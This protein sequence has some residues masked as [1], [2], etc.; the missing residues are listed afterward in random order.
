[1]IFS[2]ERKITVEINLLMSV[3]VAIKTSKDF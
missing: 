3:V 2:N 1:M